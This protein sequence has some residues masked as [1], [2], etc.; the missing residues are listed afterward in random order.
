MHSPLEE[1]ARKG[2]NIDLKREEEA[3]RAKPSWSLALRITSTSVSGVT[4]TPLGNL[5][6]FSSLT[7]AAKHTSAFKHKLKHLNFA[8]SEMREESSAVPGAFLVT[9]VK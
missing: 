1:Q 2:R 5:S 3:K 6:S 7:A 8:I 4:A 9:Y